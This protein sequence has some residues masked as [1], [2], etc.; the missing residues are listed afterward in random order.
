MPAT[1]VPWA[2]LVWPI[3]VGSLVL[4]GLAAVVAGGARWGRT[5]LAVWRVALVLL[6]LLP[7]AEVS[8]LAA[9]LTP[10]I[11]GAAPAPLADVVEESSRY[12]LLAAVA[13][14]PARPA[15]WPFAVWLAGACVVLGRRAAGTVAL[16]RFRRRLRVPAPADLVVRV[17]TVGRRC[18]YRRLVRVRVVP[19]L[20]S[21]LVFGVRRPVL[22]VPP[23][24]ADTFTPAQ[25]EAVIAHELG[26][27]AHR[28]P[29]WQWVA[30]AAGAVGWW[31]PVVWWRG[32][33]TGQPPRPPPTSSRPAS[34]TG[35]AS[36]P[37]AWSCSAAG[38]P[39][40]TW[41]GR[42]R[43]TAGCGQGWPCGSA[44]CSASTRRPPVDGAGSP[45]AVTAALGVVLL[46][47]ALGGTAWARPASANRPL[48]AAP[49]HEP[50][51]TLGPPAQ[52]TADRAEVF[53]LWIVCPEDGRSDE[54]A[55]SRLG[56]TA[57]QWA[58]FRWLQA[59]I[60]TETREMYQMKT[61]YRERGLEINRKW[62]GGLQQV[63]SPEQYRKY[64]AYWS[65]D[66][67]PAM[68]VK[69]VPVR[70]MAR[71]AQPLAPGAPGRVAAG[72]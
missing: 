71:P 29:L 8:G 27:L 42:W 18:G 32:P 31:N 59:E 63:L 15:R 61:G 20:R 49:V 14:Q 16:V 55:L 19:G 48:W 53:E 10:R 51:T 72:G 67:V 11:R 50:E 9:R 45:G 30:A 28:D 52:W 2:A 1:L 13:P 7:A 6:V 26:H 12:G 34:R 33:G 3:L 69:A 57:D 5:R 24:F 38:W 58:R 37:S 68:P 70:Q 43:P 65:G 46:L 17:A 47:A 56:L 4:V 21:P 22:A 64:V 62:L 40:R 60:D 35:R 44:G 66:P 25:Q 39:P 36:W 23:D 54:A 41:P